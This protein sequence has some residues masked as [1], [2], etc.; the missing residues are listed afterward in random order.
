M[1]H[2]RIL[3]SA[4]E[5]A[6]SYD[7]WLCD[8]W[9]VLHNGMRA[10]AEAHAAC[11]AFRAA[12][13]T[14]VLIS[15]APRPFDSVA[16]QLDG[17][18]VPRSAYDAIV[19][20][21]DVTRSL[22]TGLQG[23]PIYHLGPERDLPVF[24]GLDARLSGPDSAEAVVCTGLVNDITETPDDY[25]QQLRGFRARALPFI[26]ANPDLVVERGND[27][28]YCAGALAAAYEAIGGTVAYAGKPHRPIYDLAQ[29]AAERHRAGAVPK[30]RVLAVGDGLKTDMAGAAAFGIPALFIP[31]GVHVTPGRALD[32]GL[33][34]ELFA[35]AGWRPVAA[36]GRLEW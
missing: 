31:S 4:A 16:R 30:S 9:G 18:G 36:I 32:N 26:C 7:V 5:I 1:T 21:G 20:S 11:T 34:A 29:A 25:R 17:L 28:V 12:G 35:G 2:T 23:R 22:V 10:F 27:V 3:A 33:I 14:V 13:G 8:V 19:T 6:P 15:N 24:A